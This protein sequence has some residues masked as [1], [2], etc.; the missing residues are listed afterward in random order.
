M[1]PPIDALLR[2]D[3]AELTPVEGGALERWMARPTGSWSAGEREAA[4]G[5]VYEQLGW[6][7]GARWGAPARN[8]LVRYLVR[9]RGEALGAI[10][11][12]RAAGAAKGALVEAQMEG[13][14]TDA[15][16]N[17]IWHAFL[18]HLRD[19]KHDI[20]QDQLTYLVNSGFD[21]F[22]PERGSLDGFITMTFS[23]AA[24]HHARSE[25]KRRFPAQVSAG[26]L[27]EIGRVA[28]EGSQ[29]H[30]E[31]VAIAGDILEHVQQLDPQYRQAIE[32]ALDPKLSREQAAERAGCTKKGTFAI[33][34]M[35]ARQELWRI[36]HRVVEEPKS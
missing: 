6:L 20:L 32:L 26:R 22:D 19:F 28:L 25:I 3:P 2:K 27:V 33:R 9:F 36:I 23:R 30:A 29:P 31:S 5:W 24:A 7:P 16:R 1:A 14:L 15:D 12:R 17:L 35:R 4:D 8:V 21:S 11:A 18:E 13:G 10:C 34:L